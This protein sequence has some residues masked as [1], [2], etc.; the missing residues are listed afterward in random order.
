MRQRPP[1]AL[2]Y[3]SAGVGTPHCLKAELFKSMTDTDTVHIPYRG[4]VPAVSDV[5]SGRV[6]VLFSIPNTLMSF[7]SA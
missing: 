5:D 1:R 3:A 4:G 7:V 6:Q 2:S